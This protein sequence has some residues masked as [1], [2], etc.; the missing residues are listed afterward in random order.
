[1]AKSSDIYVKIGKLSV[2]KTD[3]ETKIKNA[4][5]GVMQKAAEAFFKGQSGMTLKQPQ[6]KDAEGFCVS[7]TATTLAKETKGKKELV[8]C[9]VNLAL[10]KLPDDKL[11][12]GKLEGSAATEATKDLRGDAEAVLSAAVTEAAKMAVKQIKHASKKAS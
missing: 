9:V 11:V 5:S 7:G 6:G 4:A 12:P 3:F 8:K 2:K 10:S 1:M